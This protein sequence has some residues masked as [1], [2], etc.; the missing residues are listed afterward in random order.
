MIRLD[1]FVSENTR[2]SRSEVKQLL[3]AKRI[4]LNNEP[5]KN[6]SF[7]LDPLIDTVCIDDTQVSARGHLYLMLNKPDGCVSANTDAEFPT[8][9]DLL[10]TAENFVCGTPDKSTL[11]DQIQH[12]SLQ[13][14]GRLDKDTT[15]LLLL[16][17]DGDWNHR[18]SSANSACRKCY[19]AELAEPVRADYAVVFAEG[20][21]L[22][23]EDKA[24]KPAFYE[25]VGEKKAK[26]TISEGRY[27][28]VK[29]MF[30]AVGNRVT[31]LTRL[32]VGELALDEN[33]KPGQFRCL[34]DQEV[35]LFQ[36]S[37]IGQGASTDA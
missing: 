8:V 21:E 36:P 29:R 28:Q 4:T 32:S 25:A 19:E 12:T 22:K 11:L 24:C 7:K 18:I 3:A 14:V 16:T 31:S 37:H 26:L 1:R 15:G 5:I 34:T 20:I 23:N 6:A 9:L 27:H 13:I 33:L 30:A 10:Q 2:Y 17:T 35:S